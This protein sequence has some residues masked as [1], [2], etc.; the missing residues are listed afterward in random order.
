MT[1]LGRLVAALLAICGPARA[2]HERA[3][4]FLTPTWVDVGPGGAAAPGSEPAPAAPT[5]AVVA[6]EPSREISREAMAGKVA[7]YVRETYGI[8]SE[9]PLLRAA[10]A[11]LDAQVRSELAKL[12][13]EEYRKFQED[14]ATIE[15]AGPMGKR[16]LR[17]RLDEEMAGAPVSFPPPASAS[18]PPPAVPQAAPPEPALDP[19][20]AYRVPARPSP[21]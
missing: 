9:T 16:F 5:R 15:R 19:S 8:S 18:A 4:L 7:D 11:T 3:F 10:G 6:G 17:S 2:E 12:S 13:A 1:R 21:R 14:V 20:L